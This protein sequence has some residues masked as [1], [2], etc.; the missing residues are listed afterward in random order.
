[1]SSMMMGDVDAHVGV[2]YMTNTSD[3]RFQIAEAA[4]ALLRGEQWPPAERKVV[5]VDP[6]VLERYVGT[7]EVGNDAFTITRVAASLF[8]QKN[9]NP[10]KGELLAETPTMF[11]LKGDPATISFEAN[12][13]GA[14]D[15]MVIAPPDWVISVARRHR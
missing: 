5:Q 9:K 1:M 11:F 4:I 14:V 13:V 15:R 2:Y 10:K 6:N 8:V 3:D 12:P 7:Y